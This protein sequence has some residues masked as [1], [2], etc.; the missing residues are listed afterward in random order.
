MLK[1][2]IMKYINYLLPSAFLILSNQ[3]FS[4]PL[5]FYGRLWLGVSNS[6]HGISG[7]EKVNGFSLENYASYL[8]FKGNY[9]IHEDISLIYKFEAGIESFDN[10]DTNIFKPRNSYLG[11]KAKYGSIVFGRNDTVFKSA[12]GKIDLF[13]I[14][15]SDM[16][17]IIAGND[18]LGDLVTINTTKIS[19]MSLGITY[20]FD[21]DF[22]QKNPTLSDKQNNYAVSLAYGDPSFKKENS[23]FSIAYADGLN[24]LEATRL[25]AGVAISSVKFGG[26]YQHSQSSIYENIKGN[27]YLLSMSIP[28]DKY[29]LKLQYLKDDAG[30]GKITKNAGADL[31]TLK[32]SDASQYSIGVGYNLMKELSFGANVS[33][34]DGKYSDSKGDNEFNDTLFTFSTKYLF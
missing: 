13:N 23:Y 4:E 16:N 20:A 9:D 26:M 5:D 28:F 3:A 18:R 10:D 21:D 19:G 25:V 8:G 12:E 11:F 1:E 14:T 24:M 34:F 7:N 33:Y 31:K 22:N 27:S 32:N 30:L 2:N 17:M 29:E 6:S 15:S